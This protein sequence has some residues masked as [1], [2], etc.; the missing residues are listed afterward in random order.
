MNQEK[1]YSA[2]TEQDI[3]NGLENGIFKEDGT[4]I[5]HKNG[6]IVKI[7]K[8]ENKSIENFPSTLVQFNTIN[9]NHTIIYQTDIQPYI[10]ELI[11]N[12]HQ[13]LV[14][15]LN[16][17]YSKVIDTLSHYKTYEDRLEDLNKLSLESLSEFESF[18]KDIKQKEVTNN[19]LITFNSY[20]DIL[21]IYMISTYKL[22]NK[23]I[24]ADTIIKDKITKLNTQVQYI[25]EQLLTKSSKDHEGKNNIN[26]NDSLYAKF[27]LENRNDGKGIGKIEKYIKY[28]SRFSSLSN[29]IVFIQKFHIKYDNYNLNKYYISIDIEKHNNSFYTRNSEDNKEEIVQRLFIILEKINSFYKIYEELIELGQV[30]SQKVTSYLDEKPFKLLVI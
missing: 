23:K 10:D 28:D 12:K 22:Y 17:S 8:N 30:A 26:L 15:N 2:I 9:I 16:T 27:L 1:K 20:I 21:F 6:E 13:K 24:S 29:F 3:N 25:Y 19:E 14:E 7:V 4:L 18:L 11:K 5:R